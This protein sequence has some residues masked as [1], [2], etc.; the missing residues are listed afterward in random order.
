[1]SNNHNDPHDIYTLLNTPPC[2]RYEGGEYNGRL[3]KVWTYV[4]GLVG[5]VPY[6]GFLSQDIARLY[7]YKGL[8]VIATHIKLTPHIEALFR[9]AW[10]E[11][12]CEFDDQVEFVSV[13][14]E[15]WKLLWS[16][17]RFES[18]WRP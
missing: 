9:K 1:M 3:V 10:V 2:A 11:V 13:R 5:G 15:R 16:L 8:L 7:D 12:G 14:S 18:D 17:R 4:A 6:V